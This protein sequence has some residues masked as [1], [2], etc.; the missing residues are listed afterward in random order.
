MQKEA[1]PF[2]GESQ[3]TIMCI[4]ERKHISVYNPND[5]KSVKKSP[6]WLDDSLDYIN[7][8]IVHDN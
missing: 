5:Y 3:R 6:V 4:I 1:C 2:L 7:F 8:D